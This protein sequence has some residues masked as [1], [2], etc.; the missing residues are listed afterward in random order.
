[1]KRI[2][3][4]VLLA[5]ISF[6]V[7]MQSTFAAAPK[8]APVPTAWQLDIEYKTPQAIQVTLPGEKPAVYWYMVYKVTNHT[9]ADQLFVPEFVLYT[10]T[11]QVL[12]SG[13]GVPADVFAEIQKVT[14][15]PLLR[16]AVGMTGKLL[17]G[18]DNAKTGLA[19][20]RDF[21]PKAGWFDVFIG[22]LSGETKDMPLPT[23]IQAT[24]VDNE[25]KTTTVTKNSVVLAK[26]LQ[27]S[28]KIAGEASS[29]TTVQAEPVKSDWVMR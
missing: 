18:D 20:W 8:P 26:T 24:V 7:W 6:G 21:D 22:G 23:P 2:A 5:A 16:D 14:N 29:R 25:G 15:N 9:G 17:Q 10:R 28:Y 11:G 19:I 3:V 12:R 4:T 13:Q 1:M 27:L